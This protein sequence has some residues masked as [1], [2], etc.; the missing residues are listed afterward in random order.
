M[1]QLLNGQIRQVD[2]GGLCV[3]MP[4]GAG[5][6]LRL[7]RA[8]ALPNHTENGNCPE[9]TP[10]W[11][12]VPGISRRRN[13]GVSQIITDPRPPSPPFWLV[14]HAPIPPSPRA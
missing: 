5:K 10:P 4:D 2:R 14:P 13:G 9:G 8:L 1:P 7:R 3:P 11:M 12:Q 6:T